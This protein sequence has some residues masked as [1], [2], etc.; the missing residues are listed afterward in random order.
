[1]GCGLF[2]R[3]R[4]RVL[5]VGPATAGKEAI[6]E[7]FGLEEVVTAKAV[8]L[9]CPEFALKV[10]VG[11][12]VELITCDLDNLDCLGVTVSQ[13]LSICGPVDAVVSV[14]DCANPAC[15]ADSHLQLTSLLCSAELSGAPCLVFADRQN[16]PQAMP[17]W[18]IA[19]EFCCHMSGRPWS[20]Q[21]LSD[22]QPKGVFLG[23]EWLVDSCSRRRDAPAPTCRSARRRWKQLEQRSLGAL[24]QLVMGVDRAASSCIQSCS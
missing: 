20:V 5:L 11:G 16:M 10:H 1:M 21:G 3:R 17:A 15:I 19:E 14:I 22:K 9:W 24:K 4:V 23:V 12:N 13:F 8:P 18:Q 2:E 7:T 6:V